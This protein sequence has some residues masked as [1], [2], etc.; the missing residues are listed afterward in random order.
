MQTTVLDAM[1]EFYEGMLEGPAEKVITANSDG[2][3]YAGKAVSYDPDLAANVAN[4]RNLCHGFVAEEV[5]EGITFTENMRSLNSAGYAGYND[6]DVMAVL[7]R[8]KVWVKTADAITDLSSGVWALG[9]G[10]GTAPD[11][12][13]GSFRG[14]TAENYTNLS[15]TY[16]LKWVKAKTVG[17]TNYGL[18]A[19]NMG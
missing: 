7:K 1:P 19:V 5:V 10:A 9:A 13:L 12:A 18:L 6:E 3:T 2:V 16:D 8:G 17:S 4:D 15:T 14:T 11:A